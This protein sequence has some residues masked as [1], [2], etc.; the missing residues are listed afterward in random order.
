MY[1]RQALKLEAFTVNFKAMI[2]SLLDK[3]VSY[4]KLV[5]GQSPFY[6]GKLFCETIMKSENL[7]EILALLLEKY[8]EEK[9]QNKEKFSRVPNK[10]V[11][12]LKWTTIMHHLLECYQLLE[13]FTLHCSLCLI[14]K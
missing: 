12:R 13:C 6:K 9:E 5:E 7:D 8:L 4:E 14:N 3:K 10:L 1:K 11:S 2:V